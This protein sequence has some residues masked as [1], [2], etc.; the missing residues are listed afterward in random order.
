[1]FVKP[2][3]RMNVT[4]ASHIYVCHAKAVQLSMIMRVSAVNRNISGTDCTQL[5][6]SHVIILALRDLPVSVELQATIFL[7]TLWM[8]AVSVE[9]WHVSTV[10]CCGV[11]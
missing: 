6:E 11:T 9:K 5:G 8:I 7:C 10:V 2:L 3:I 1:M 4:M